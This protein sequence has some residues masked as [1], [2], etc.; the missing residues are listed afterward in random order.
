[1]IKKIISGIILLLLISV[2]IVQAMDKKKEPELPGLDVGGKA[3]NFT[4]Q[5]LEGENVS[6]SDYK[7]K[8]VILN[9]WATWCPPCRK[10]MPALEKFYQQN[11]NKIEILAINTDPKNDVAGYVN[12]MNLTFPILLDEKSEVSGQYD[13]LS[14][15]TTY[16]IDEKG[17][18]VKKQIGEL[19]FEQLNQIMSEL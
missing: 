17:K 15:P 5:N 1:M 19:T 16:F 18:L 8:K 14:L 13:I 6:L 4:L 12:S 11:K 10:E 2:A 3:P 7:G 9:F